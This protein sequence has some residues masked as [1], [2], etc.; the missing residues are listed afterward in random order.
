M[1]I[2]KESLAEKIVASIGIN[3]R[4]ATELVEHF[5]AEIKSALQNGQEIKLSN[6]GNFHLADKKARIG[7]NPK[8]GQEAPISA[9]R[10]VTFRAG[11]NL[12]D[13][14]EKYAAGPKT[15]E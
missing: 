8:T 3:K 14:V 6:F 7:R 13:K 9:R 15:N 10:V 11:P 4:E 1:T 5:F 2:T 12:K